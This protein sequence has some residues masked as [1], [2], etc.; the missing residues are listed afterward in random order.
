M[1]DYKHYN[2]N[3]DLKFVPQI[4]F[5]CNVSHIIQLMTK[6]LAVRTEEKEIVHKHIKNMPDGKERQTI[7]SL[8]E[9]LSSDDNSDTFSIHESIQI[10]RKL[11]TLYNKDPKNKK[12]PLSDKEDA[13]IQ[14]LKIYFILV[15]YKLYNYLNSYLGTEDSM[16]KKHLSFA[17]RHNNYNLY[18]EIK[19]CLQLIFFTG[20]DNNLENDEIIEIIQ[21]ILEPTEHNNTIINL[22]YWANVKEK[23][24]KLRGSLSHNKDDFGNPLY[25]IQ[26]YFMHFETPATN[27][28]YDMD[29]NPDGRDWLVSNNIDEKSTKFDLKN[30]VLIVEFRDF[31]SYCYLH[32]F[33]T[34]L[35]GGLWHGAN[36]TFILWGAMHGL[37][38]AADKLRMQWLKKQQT[39]SLRHST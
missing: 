18:L 30:D 11:F 3:R 20:N 32:L 21:N 27:T 2:I 23:R 35:L 24:D 39:I 4:T 28:D 31:P 33:I 15:F 25:S 19:R 22:I 16:L 8:I 34:M 14:K 1:Y 13:N 29:E 17:V 10:V 9:T 26:K 6:M 37:A 38:L 7:S 36:W 12:Y 5:G